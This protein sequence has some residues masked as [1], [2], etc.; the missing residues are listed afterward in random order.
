MES[1][2]GLDFGVVE[3]E[4]NRVFVFLDFS[5]MLMEVPDLGVLES[6]FL[7]TDAR[8]AD[9]SLSVARFLLELGFEQGTVFLLERDVA[10]VAGVE[11]GVSLVRAIVIVFT[12]IED[13]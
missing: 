5:I 8:F 1:A 4:L 13:F 10:R 9:D 2:L 6:D 12:S 11:V 3:F 7:R